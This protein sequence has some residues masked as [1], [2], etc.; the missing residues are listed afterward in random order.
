MRRQRDCADS[1]RVRG[2]VAWDSSG[3]RFVL[4]DVSDALEIAWHDRE[5][6]W[7]VLSPIFGMLALQGGSE[8][9]R[10]AVAPLLDAAIS[11]LLAGAG[12]LFNDYFIVF[13]FLLC[14]F[15]FW[16]FLPFAL[17]L[18][19]PLAG[20]GLLFIHCPLFS[21]LFIK[22]SVFARF[23]VVVVSSFGATSQSQEAG[24]SLAAEARA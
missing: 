6:H 24:G 18:R 19:T 9:Q 20:A 8:E 11:R 17:F 7:Q 2:F 10:M 22:V 16:F 23:F 1:G 12:L 5:A 3:S 15:F 13:P 14:L 21:L 4:P